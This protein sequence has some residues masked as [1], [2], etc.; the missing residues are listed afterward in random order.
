MER[1]NTMSK[2]KVEPQS[3]RAERLKEIIKNEGLTQNLL[4]DKVSVT[5]QSISRI[6]QGKQALTEGMARRIVA[7]FPAYNVE[8]L[9][10]YKSEEE[11]RTGIIQDAIEKMISQ[12]PKNVEILKEIIN[13]KSA[14]AKDRMT[15][16][17]MLNAAE[18]KVTKYYKQLER[19]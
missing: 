1:A 3:V 13:D 12:F 6:M 4:A 15:A 2:A 18:S 19:R 14:S 9:L 8:W 10:G 17:R 16:I 11:A 5:Q 7:V